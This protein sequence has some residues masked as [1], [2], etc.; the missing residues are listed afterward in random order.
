MARNGPLAWRRSH[1]PALG[2]VTLGAN[3]KLFKISTGGRFCTWWLGL[4]R[5]VSYAM[6]HFYFV[7]FLVGVNKTVGSTYHID[8]RQASAIVF[9]DGSNVY[10]HP[11][12]PRGL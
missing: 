8:I 9:G 1:Q 11:P 3:L 2:N 10:S 5:K 12:V 6:F 7:C 4:L